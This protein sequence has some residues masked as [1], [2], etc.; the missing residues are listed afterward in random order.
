V[1]IS[2]FQA[3]RHR[4]A[5]TLVAI[6]TAEAVIDA[7]WLDGSP[8]TAAMAKATAGREA[9]TAACHCQQVL[10]GIGFTTE[11]PFHLYFR[12]VLVLDALL[13]TSRALT[14]ALGEDLLAGRQLPPLLPL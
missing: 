3:V 10:A 6:E 8:G 11:H 4:L 5:E 2:S 1:P 14:R 9:R 12:R 13:G 7:A